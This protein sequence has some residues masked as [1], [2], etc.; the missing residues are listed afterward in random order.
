[1]YWVIWFTFYDT[2]PPFLQICITQCHLNTLS[3]KEKYIP[4][5]SESEY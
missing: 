2:N 5:K 1:M 4:E 3:V